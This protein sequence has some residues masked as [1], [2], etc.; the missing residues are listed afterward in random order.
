MLYRALT[1]VFLLGLG[2]EAQAHI[3]SDSILKHEPTL[4]SFLKKGT[5]DFH[6]RSF[7]MG[8]RNKGLLT[9]YHTL[10]SG[11]GVGYYSPNFRG[12]SV[13]MSGFFV[14]RLWQHNVDLPDISTNAT[15]RYEIALYDMNDFE[16]GKDLDRLEEIFIDYRF[17]KSKITWGRQ[18]FNSPFLNEQDNRMRPN[19]FNGFYANQASEKTQ[20]HL[21][22]FYAVTMRGT[23]DWYKLK[24]SYGVYPFGRSPFGTPSNYKGQTN[25]K[26]IGV[27]GIQH[28]PTASSRVDF[29]QYV[30]E[31][32][33]ALSYLS[34]FKDVVYKKQHFSFG[35]QGYYQQAI[36]NGGNPDIRKA[37][38]LPNEKS[39]G[40]GSSMVLK[41]KKYEWSLN[42]LSMGGEGRFLFPREWGREQF[43]ASLPRER[44]EGSGNI[45]ALTAKMKYAYAD[46]AS[47]FHTG[48]SWVKHADLT[49]Y[50]KNKYGMPSYFHWVVGYDYFL[51]GYWKGLSFRFLIVHKA[52]V[53]PESV[54]D[55]Y[56]INRVDLWH[57]NAII[58]Y[59]L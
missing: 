33:F 19:L 34:V 8:T 36:G 56:R 22:W 58:D 20:L 25:S 50:A 32:V 47:M 18:K 42:H 41:K 28:K 45:L 40:L 37:Y 24:D 11:A 31:N 4:E 39:W 16:N 57:F 3:D 48:M 55:I 53:S 26:G 15:N 14:F 43:F 17:R 46:S 51:K 2:L 35:F 44:F 27:L 10:A 1:F 7:F 5:F 38:I 52:A 30:N 21:A 54:S 23:V 6:T 9:D 12:F 49:N 29:W 13:G 59:R